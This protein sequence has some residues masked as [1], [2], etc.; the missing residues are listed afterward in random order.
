MILSQA[1]AGVP[2]SKAL[3][4]EGRQRL[5]ALHAGGASGS[6]VVAAMSD[7]IDQ[8][9]VTLYQPLLGDL[10]PGEREAADTDVALVALGGFGRR[11]L[12]PYSDVD[13]MLLY[14]P[15]A[16]ALAGPLS[17][18]LFRARWDTGLHLGHSVRTVGE[19]MALARQDVSVATALTEPRLLA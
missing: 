1:S 7:L 2:Q 9:V 8:L 11:E 4:A 14:G 19:C 15:A 12:A 13:L 17:A 10:P 18:R 5:R 6:H 3:L 16:Q